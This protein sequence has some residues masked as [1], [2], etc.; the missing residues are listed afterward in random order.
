MKYVATEQNVKSS[1]YKDGDPGLP[2]TI[3]TIIADDVLSGLKQYADQN[4]IDLVVMVNVEQGYLES[5]FGKSISKKMAL[6]SKIPLMIY[7]FK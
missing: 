3:E 2:I 7:H 5:L 1:L 4:A 6:G